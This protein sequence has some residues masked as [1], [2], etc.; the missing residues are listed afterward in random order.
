MHFD[1]VPN[2]MPKTGSAAA[3]ATVAAIIAAA[4]AA[5]ATVRCWLFSGCVA[6]VRGLTTPVSFAGREVTPTHRATGG[7]LQE[8]ALYGWEACGSRSE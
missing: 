5:T 4:A 2:R 3:T 7:V 8:R 6:W 1:R